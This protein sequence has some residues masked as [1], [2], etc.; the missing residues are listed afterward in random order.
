MRGTTTGDVH[1][2]GIILSNSTLQ[3]NPSLISTKGLFGYPGFNLR[4]NP[5]WYDSLIYIVIDHLE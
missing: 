5:T 3:N 4:N 1:G 2:V